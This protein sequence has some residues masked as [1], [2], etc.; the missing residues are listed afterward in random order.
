M[1]ETAP[2]APSFERSVPNK[3]LRGTAKFV[4]GSTVALT[5]VL[6][7]SGALDPTT[8]TTSVKGD[9]TLVFIGDQVSIPLVENNAVYAGGDLI[10][11]VLTLGPVDVLPPSDAWA[12]GL[13]V[14]DVE[15]VPEGMLRL[16]AYEDEQ[17]GFYILMSE[18]D[19]TESKD[20]NINND[21]IIITTDQPLSCEFSMERDSAGYTY[22]EPS[23]GCK[24]LMNNDPAGWRGIEETSFAKGG[25]FGLGIEDSPPTIVRQ[26]VDTYLENPRCHIG[27]QFGLTAAQKLEWQPAD[28][29]PVQW[30]QGSDAYEGLR[31]TLI[32]RYRKKVSDLTQLPLTVQNGR[33]MF[34]TASERDFLLKVAEVHGPLVDMNHMEYAS[35]VQTELEKIDGKIVPEGARP[36]RFRLGDPIA[37]ELIAMKQQNPD[38][39]ID[40]LTDNK[41]WDDEGGDPFS[42]VLNRNCLPQLPDK[43]DEYKLEALMVSQIGGLNGLTPGTILVSDP[44]KFEESRTLERLYLFAGPE[45]F[46]AKHY[47]Q[48]LSDQQIAYRIASYKQ[49]QGLVVTAEEVALMEAVNAAL[50]EQEALS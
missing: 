18:F 2:I 50:A 39:V 47:Y 19:G 29:I 48:I 7:A 32:A 40:R 6:L 17:I 24:R 25:V 23:D 35:A 1:S 8:K 42:F 36:D 9:S 14:Q 27:L 44:D 20:F 28:N 46:F 30:Y 5:G 37:K 33:P 3:V 15:Y 43:L 34:L 22:L 49:R 13:Y 31:L 26:V 41:D 4:V 45:N 21:S 16:D 38:L 10:E 12:R 11:D